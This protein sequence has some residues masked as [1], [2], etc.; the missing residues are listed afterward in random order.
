MS[1]FDLVNFEDLDQFEYA[2]PELF[3]NIV[4]IKNLHIIQPLDEMYIIEQYIQ[5]EIEEKECIKSNQTINFDNQ[6]TFGNTVTFTISK[7]DDLSS[8]T[9]PS[10]TNYNNNLFNNTITNDNNINYSTG[11]WTTI[12]NLIN[13]KPFTQNNIY[14]FALYPN[15]HQ[16]SGTMNI[17]YFNQPTLSFGFDNKFYNNQIINSKIQKPISQS[18]I[19]NIKSYTKS[20][21]FELKKKLPYNFQKFI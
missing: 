2:K 6:P 15:E 21:N 10:I 4:T 3:E 12:N 7:Y 13:N 14:S 16:P 17:S 5:Q 8:N 11:N 19:K 20:Q 1:S 9:I 18:N